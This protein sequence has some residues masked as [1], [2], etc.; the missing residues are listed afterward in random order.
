M[1]NSNQAH[2]D[3]IVGFPPF[4]FCVFNLRKFD[5]IIVNN[6]EED[7]FRYRFVFVS[8]LLIELLE[9]KWV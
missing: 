2:T 1:V 4:L 3:S 9:Q 5:C 8:C 6:G 7:I